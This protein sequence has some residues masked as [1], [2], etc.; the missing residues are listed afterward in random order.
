MIT[1]PSSC[2]LRMD[3]HCPWIANCVG[4]RK[5]R[6][7]GGVSQIVLGECHAKSHWTCWLHIFPANPVG[8]QMMHVTFRDPELEASLVG[9]A[10]QEHFYLFP[11]L[12]GITSTS[13]CWHFGNN[14]CRASYWRWDGEITSFSSPQICW[15]LNL[16]NETIFPDA[17]FVSPMKTPMEWKAADSQQ[18]WSLVPLL[19]W[20]F[21]RGQTLQS[22]KIKPV[23][24][25]FHE[26]PLA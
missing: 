17:L 16:V 2:V 5:R 4:F 7:Q 13:S 22:W 8:L 23:R 21:Q 25:I 15:V 20:T 3:H 1:S 18:T 11:W 14:F 24:R 10:S 12:A 19:W 26:A 6:W 9:A